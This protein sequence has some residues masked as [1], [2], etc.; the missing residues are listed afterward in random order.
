MSLRIMPVVGEALNFGARRFETVARVTALPIG[1]SVIFNMAAVFAYLSIANNRLITFTDLS[2]AGVSYKMAKAMAGKAAYQGLAAGSHQIWIIYAVSVAINAILVAVFMAPLIRYAGL[3]ER[4]APGLIRA[5]FGM[6]QIRYLCAGAVT[7]VFS[8]VLIYAPIGVVTYWIIKAITKAIATPFAHF[9]NT[10]SLH[11]IDVISGA[12]GLARRG[13][14]WIYEYGFWTAAGI[15]TLA[16]LFAVLM[17]HFAPAGQERRPRLAFLGRAVSILAWGGL[18]LFAVYRLLPKLTAAAGAQPNTQIT[19]MAMFAAA[20]LAVAVYVNLR[21]YPYIGVVICRRSMAL[22][23]TFRVTRRFNL[24]RLAA[25]M[26]LLTGIL[27][28]VQMALLFIAGGG[29]LSVL[30]YL[31]AGVLT[32]VR[33]FDNAPNA[34][35]WVGPLFQ[36]LWATIGMISAIV[37]AMFTY[38]V[39]AALLGRLYRE[40]ERL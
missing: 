15:A 26:A 19:S 25:V 8:A 1:L 28:L 10:E 12:D 18:Y 34:G 21:L 17:A 6:D 38:G 7:F 3:G 9:P 23:G 13:V 35:A 37:W 14:S 2:E 27:W 5:P 31:Y 32:L 22:A 40:S 33:F 16:V 39:S 20:A 29:A 30:Q 4:P 36:A 24:L 11:S